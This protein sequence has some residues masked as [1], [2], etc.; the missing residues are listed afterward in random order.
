MKKLFVSLL[1]MLF[2]LS[3]NAQLLKNVYRTNKPVLRIPIHLI[4]RVETVNQNGVSY[5]RILQLNGYSNQIPTTEIDSITHSEG[6]S[7]DPSFLGEAHLSDVIGLVLDNNNSPVYKAWV[8]NPYSDEGVFTDINGVFHLRDIPVFEQLGF[9][10]VE[11]EG[12]HKGS[13]SFLPL[14]SGA[15]QVRIQLLPKVLSGSFNS[16]SGGIVD[17]GILQLE[18]PANAIQLNGQLYNGTVNVF[19]QALD[20]GSSDMYDQMPGELLGG[21]NDSLRLLRSFGMATVELLTPNLEKLQI[22]EGNNV[23]L[24][25][26]IPDLLLSDAPESMDWWS[27]D[28]DQGLWMHEGVVQKQGNQYV[29][30]A[31]HFSW[32]NVDFPDL[33]VNFNGVL[34][35]LNGEPIGGAQVKVISPTMGTGIL[36]TNS[37]GGF[38]GRVPRNQP[39]TIQFYLPCDTSGSQNLALTESLTASTSDF[40]QT[41]SAGFSAFFPLSGKIVNCSGNPVSSGYVKIGSQIYFSTADSFRVWLCE[42]GPIEIR[43]FDTSIPDST[44]ASELYSVN[45]L[46][47]GFDV[48]EVQACSSGFGSVYDIDGNIYSTVLIGNQL[49]MAENLRTGTFN[50]GTTVPNLVDSNDWINTTEAAWCSYENNS[51]N[52]DVYGKLYNWYVVSDTRNICPIGWHIPTQS[53]WDTLMEHLGGYLVAGGKLK[54]TGTQFWINPNDATN[55]SGFSALGAGYRNVTNGSFAT[56][57]TRSYFWTANETDLDIADTRWLMNNF[58]L[59][60]SMPYGKKNGFSIRCL[61]N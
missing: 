24:A 33:F 45:V 55:E 34:L 59:M 32:W 35:D 21:K 43:V 46:A 13:R 39:L 49:W 11:K 6:F 18:F 9:V 50:D 16:A 37:E 10:T 8:S 5:L 3:M 58:V 47:S 26:D 2:A 61:S 53:E 41:F 1:S 29:G 20:V 17:A 14:D 4:D 31:T 30:L 36:F 27:F 56:L 23:T 22:S 19:A 15:I 25:F 38:S 51:S 48:G 42:T 52:E 54:I 60:N 57:G 12:Y 40:S 28:E 44:K 7:I